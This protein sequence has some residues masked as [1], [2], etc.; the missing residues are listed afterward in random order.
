[1]DRVMYRYA[2]KSND[3]PICINEVTRQNRYDTTYR[4]PYCNNEMY[5]A[6]G[7]IRAHHFR[8]NGSECEPDKYL[9]ST[10]EELFHAEFNKCLA[11]N[12]PFIIEYNTDVKCNLPY[13]CY[14][15]DWNTKVCKE[16]CHSIAVDLT[17][18][19]SRI[20]K[21][22]CVRFGDHYRRPDLLLS[23]EDGDKL[24]VEI[25]VT[26]ETAIDKR[27]DGKILEIKIESEKDLEQIRNHHIVAKK[28]DKS[29]VRAFNI[30]SWYENSVVR[31]NFFD[32]S[33][34]NKYYRNSESVS[35]K[36]NSDFLGD[37]P[38]KDGS[39]F[40]GNIPEKLLEYSESDSTPES[41]W[42]DLGLPSHTY[43]ARNDQKSCFSGP[44]ALIIHGTWLPTIEQVQELYE[45][46]TVEYDSQGNI[47]FTGPSN[48][49]I[50]FSK[51]SSN[52]GHWIKSFNETD[53]RYSQC[54]YAKADMTD[55]IGVENS[56]I[57]LF[58]RKVSK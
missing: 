42:V 14:Y 5:P 2:L 51:E 6:I 17:K 15:R 4:C 10:A 27:L 28:G 49:S 24:W 31:Y 18:T 9:H 52:A 53:Y 57:E 36:E 25:W 21:E 38:E 44:T 43:W 26:H 16:H 35:V 33:A 13:N 56:N 41:E 7:D 54:F 30:D 8:H 37:I 46:C 12:T 32:T 55:Y 1:M 19:Y 20:E 23:N 22:P 29:S 34:C 47:R 40:S 45:H 39:R 3:E 11:D 48:K 58:V 50:L